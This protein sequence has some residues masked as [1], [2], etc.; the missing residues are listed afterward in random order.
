MYKDFLSAVQNRRSYYNI[1]KQSPI[2]DDQIVEIVQF[3]VKHCPSAYNSQSGR[4][5]V[6]LGGEHGA[7]WGI[8][9]EA[10]RE[11]VPAEKFGRTAAKIAGFAAGYGTV[12]FFEDQAVVARMQA[13]YPAYRDNF[14]PWSLQSSGML[15]FAVWT[16]LEAQGLGASLQH[17]NPLIDDAVRRRWNIPGSWILIGQMPFGAPTEEPDE[18]EFLPIEDRVKVFQ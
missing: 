14:P 6:L 18:K 5:A 4:A 8:V 3:A 15:Q 13:E 16:A 9:L 12:L 1:S 11:R 10:L 17:Y 2:P 7:L